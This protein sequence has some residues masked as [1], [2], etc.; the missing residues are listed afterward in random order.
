MCQREF[1]VTEIMPFSHLQLGNFVQLFL[2]KSYNCLH[3][4]Q[5]IFYQTALEM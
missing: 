1:A 4:F 2:F 3:T 5:G